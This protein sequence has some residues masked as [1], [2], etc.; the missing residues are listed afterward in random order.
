M[1]EFDYK[2]VGYLKKTKN[3]VERFLPV[4]FSVVIFIL[5]GI[6]SLSIS[7]E[8]NNLT[9]NLDKFYKHPYSVRNAVSDFKLNALEVVNLWSGHSGDNLT[10]ADLEPIIKRKFVALDSTYSIIKDDY[11]GTSEESRALWE[12]YS[13][14]KNHINTTDFSINRIN[15]TESDH[16]EIN[17]LLRDIVNK[18]E[19]IEN[20]AIANADDY[21]SQSLI[22]EDFLLRKLNQLYISTIVFFVIGLI[23]AVY[24]LISKNSNLFSEKEK[25]K[26]SIDF[27]P[28][29]IVIHKNG[30]VLQLSKELT[31]LT[32]YTIEDIPTIK[33]W[34]GKIYGSDHVLPKEYLRNLYKIENP[35]DRTW[36]IKT[37]SGQE[38]IWLFHTRPIGGGT[39]I[40]TA[41][42]VTEV[43]KKQQQ[44]EEF[45]K[46]TQKLAKAVDQSPVSIMITDVKGNIEYV[47][48]Y[49]TEITGYSSD[50]VL[51]K[52]PRIMK[53]GAQ[54][55]EFYK[56]LWET[57]SSG[58]VWTGDLQNKT[59]DGTIFWESAS[60]SPIID[61]SGEV[62]DYVAV[63]D[64][65]T[66]RK[67]SQEALIRSEKQ[68][69]DLFTL[70]TDACLILKDGVYIDCNQ[71][72]LDIL[73]M[74]SKNELIGLGPADVSPEFQAGGVRS[75][76]L[77]TDKILEANN[78]KYLRFEWLHQ[79]K[80]GE[81][82]PSE[83][84]L[85]KIE[86][87][88]DS[89][90]YV[91]W[92]DITARKENEKQL[93][94]NLE[95]KE[96]LL[97]EVH[98][99]VKNNLAVISGMLELQ[100]F[101]SK[102]SKEIEALY[103][104]VN[105]IKSIA[106]IHEQLYKTGNFASIAVDDSILSQVENL[107]KIYDE[108]QNV[109]IVYDFNNVNLNVNEAIPLG[110]LVNELVTNSFKHAFNSIIDPQL[111]LSLHQV[112]NDVQFTF[113]D[114]GKGFDVDEF[115]NSSHSLGHNLMNAFVGQLGGDLDIKSSSNE[116]TRMTLT[117]QPA[118]KKGS[119]SNLV[120]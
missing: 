54:N 72:A 43:H 103:K 99:R 42:D 65:I 21:M 79:S 101:S 100:A 113:E 115:I 28:I 1:K 93:K 62:T 29:P 73:G 95:E 48:K 38:R 89:Y 12:S 112:D 117:F 60:I 13:T 119:S 105:R 37:K 55:D 57:I 77:A 15:H 76:S 71:A 81:L 41:V 39:L 52:N 34:R 59:K 118:L 111:K 69:R 25:F 87:E 22:E 67:Q 17:L 74:S 120:L 78:A 8:V 108:N 96:I 83:I 10:T 58:N 6:F 2:R 91:V 44:I 31:E 46:E 9:N 18:L 49:F 56:N 82:A 68:Y 75:D 61:D 97:A 33:E 47:N 27:V 40:S 63:K 45:Y 35:Q 66:E 32:G 30:V 5:L 107:S 24:L 86:E 90:L 7:H 102:N 19:S 51:G 26:N 88:N 4:I 53:S 116:G 50:D 109:K 110:L 14:F 16:V 20:F 114:N 92:R 98:H 23:S 84:M 104:S 80:N 64:N 106:V 70:S 36:I 85:T 3:R 11:L 94:E